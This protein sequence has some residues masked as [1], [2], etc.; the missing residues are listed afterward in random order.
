MPIVARV[1]DMAHDPLVFIICDVTI[2]E[3]LLPVVNSIKINKHW[4]NILA[5]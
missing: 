2:C 3:I 4:F 1:S 5:L